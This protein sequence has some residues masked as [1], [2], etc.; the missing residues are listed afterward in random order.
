MRAPEQAAMAGLERVILQSGWS[1]RRERG[2]REGRVKKKGK[3][4]EKE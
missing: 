4:K 1:R 2:R 3:K